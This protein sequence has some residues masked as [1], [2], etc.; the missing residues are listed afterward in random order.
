M[1]EIK[2]K[3]IRIIVT[4]LS[5]V[6]LVFVIFHLIFTGKTPLWNFLGSIPPSFFGVIPLVFLTFEVL[7]KKKRLSGILTAVFSLLLGVTQLDINILRIKNNEIPAGGYTSI[8]VFNWNTEYWDQFKDKDRFYRFL[9][10]QDADIYILQEYLHITKDFSVPKADRS[11]LFSICSVVPGFPLHYLA[12]DDRKRLREEFPGYYFVTD[13][14]FVILSRF[15][16]K[17]SHPDYSE[18]YSVTDI[19]IYGRLV[20]F[21]NVHMLLHVEPENPFQPH[22]YEALDRRYKAR[23][24]GFK[25]LKEDIKKTSTYFIAGDFNSTKAMGVMDDLLKEHVDAVKYSNELI[26]LSFGFYGLRLWRFDYGMV[27]KTNE[28]LK[29]KIYQNIDHEGLSDHNPQ[30]FVLDIKTLDK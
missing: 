18:Q 14:Q 27:P 20:R 11:K 3:Y 13:K 24:L 10:T 28:N 15:P 7:W 29:I 2:K 17:D 22:Y 26:P 6:W 23:Q 19:D 30:S 21:F 5:S 16:I 25:R 1:T 8:K 9:K 12:V 4:T